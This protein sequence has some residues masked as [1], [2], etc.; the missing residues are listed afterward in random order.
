MDGVLDESIRIVCTASGEISGGML[1]S[2]NT[3]G[4]YTKHENTICTNLEYS[5]REAFIKK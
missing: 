1:I 3:S 2:G 4:T 5:R